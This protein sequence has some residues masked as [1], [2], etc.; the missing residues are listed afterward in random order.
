VQ[1][2]DYDEFGVVT[3]NTNPGFQPF[4]YAGGL[5]DEQTGLVRFGARDYDAST[6]RW[7][8]KD[9]SG[10]DGSAGNF[11]L[12]AEGDPVNALDAAGTSPTSAI[13][14]F[15]GGAAIGVVGGVVVGGL[16]AAAVVASSP[17]IAG[18]AAVAAI[19]LAA[20]GGFST[21][22]VIYEIAAG[23]E[24]RTG[25]PLS[26]EARIDR[27]AGLA[28]GLLGGGLGA[29]LAPRVRLTHF[30]DA[31]GASDIAAAGSLR[32]GT[33]VAPPNAL[34]GLSR[35]GIEG[36]LELRPG[37]GAFSTSVE[38]SVWNLRL[39]E[40]GLL[41]SGGTRQFRLVGSVP[42]GPLTPTR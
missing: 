40:N 17:I 25:V 3:L 12:Y 9:A 28:G 30:T 38:T 29:R 18:G 21:G 6:G 16:V 1:R 36:A 26:C 41:T 14:A 39:G 37:R 7:T 4:G 42:A 10:F 24:Y 8:R 23:T 15:L 2:L 27:L 13:R 11:Y 22:A 33:Y 32:P 19:G 5:D 31:A 35:S 20:A 34:R